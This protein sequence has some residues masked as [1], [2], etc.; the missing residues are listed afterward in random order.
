MSRWQRGRHRLDQPAQ[1]A[2]DDTEPACLNSTTGCLKFVDRF[3]VGRQRQP[4]CFHL[5][6]L[7]RPIAR[8]NPI[9]EVRRRCHYRAA[10]DMCFILLGTFPHETRGDK[11]SNVGAQRAQ[12][13]P[14]LESPSLD[15]IRV[16]K[17]EVSNTV[18]Q[19]VVGLVPVA[20][21]L[22]LPFAHQQLL[23]PAPDGLGRHAPPEHD[24]RGR[25]GADR[26]GKS[27]PDEQTRPALLPADGTPRP[28][29]R[30]R[31]EARD[32]APTPTVLA[33]H[34]LADLEQWGRI[35]AEENRRRHGADCQV[36]GGAHRSVRP[37]SHSPGWVRRRER[38]HGR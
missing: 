12:P 16:G 36:R 33:V 32:P 14:G 8:S 21:P 34:P 18:Q 35:V 20:G 37:D 23:T 26:S 6:C 30:G 19:C 2:P 17:L 4:A 29:N 25:L 1:G 31:G 28:W 5:Q 24:R 3:R 38:P 10:G 9:D 11:G 7:V 22:E 15:E 13:L 27:R